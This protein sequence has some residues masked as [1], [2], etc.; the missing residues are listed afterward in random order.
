MEVTVRLTESKRLCAYY[1]SKKN[2]QVSLES[3]LE[4]HLP[5]Y[6]IQSVFVLIEEIPLTISGKIDEKRLSNSDSRALNQLEKVILNVEEKKLAELWDTVLEIERIG[7]HQN[8]FELGGHSLNL[9]ILTEELQKAGYV[10]D[11]MDIYKYPTI[12]DFLEFQ[13]NLSTVNE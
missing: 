12:V 3:Y 11:M 10:L 9:V 6:M 8:F 1:V 5:D 13:Q 2:Q 4:E 7:M